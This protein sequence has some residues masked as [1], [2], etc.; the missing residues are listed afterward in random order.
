MPITRKQE[1]KART[2]REAEM[3]SD[4]ENMDIMLGTI[5][6]SLRTVSLEIMLDFLKTLVT[7]HY[8]IIALTLVPNRVRTR[9]DNL[10]TGNGHQSNEA[11]SSSGNK[12][13]SEELNQRITQ[14]MN[15]LM[16]SVSSQIQRATSEAINEQVLPQIQATLWSRHGEVPCKAWN[17]PAEKPEHRSV[18]SFN[19]KVRSSP[20]EEFPRNLIT[21]E[22][23]ENTLYKRFT[24]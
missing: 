19:S 22:N 6:L 24:E 12:S 10:P 14:E 8:M 11:D 16:S 18:E 3:L 9:L 4:L 7:M 17:V 23:E 15:V 13:L 21:H 2:F 5:T 20:E 1:S